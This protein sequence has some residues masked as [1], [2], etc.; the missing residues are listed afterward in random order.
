MYEVNIKA[1]A[2]DFLDWDRPLSQQSEKVRAAIA[3]TPWGEPYVKSETLTGGQIVP[4]TKAGQQ[5]LR[6][7]GIPGIRYLDQ[8]SRAAGEGSRNYVVF[9]EN[10]IEI[11]RKYGLLGMLG[12]GGMVN[13][14]TKPTAPKMP[15]DAA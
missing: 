14:L 10:L 3:S 9:D 5:Q 12:A 11:L 15:D 13:E 6:E 7:A 1:N 2:D 8:G 4:R